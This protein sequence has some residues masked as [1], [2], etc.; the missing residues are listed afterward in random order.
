VT[1]VGGCVRA[2]SIP[3]RLHANLPTTP[4]KDRKIARG[5]YVTG[6][7]LLVVSVTSAAT[8]HGTVVVYHRI[9]ALQ[10]QSESV[11]I[12][13][14]AT[15]PVGRCWCTTPTTPGPQDHQIARTRGGKTNSI[16]SSL[17]GT[18][19][20]GKEMERRPGGAL[21]STDGIRGVRV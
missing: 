14:V 2:P 17:D 1:C 19:K 9:I 5:C 12:A 4:T 18:P 7:R 3:F 20:K 6:R 16:D 15:T 21:G 10:L 13:S 11:I 8:P